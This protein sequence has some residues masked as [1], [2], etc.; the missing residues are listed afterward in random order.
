MGRQVG[1]RCAAVARR[2]HGWQSGAGARTTSR[3]GA[4]AI[5]AALA[6]A[7]F[8]AAGPVAHAE[9]KVRSPIV[10]YGELEIEHNGSL[11][12]DKSKSGKNNG[13]SYTN[14]IEYGLLPWWKVEFEGEWEAEPGENLRY[15]ATSFENVFQLTEQGKYWADFGFFAEYSHA[16]SRSDADSF[17]FGPIVQKELRDF[18]GTDTLHTVNLLVSKQVGHNRTDDTGFSYAWQSRYLLHPL[19]EPGIEFYG[20]IG[21]VEAPGKLADQSHRLGPMFAGE[22]SLAP[23]GA[24]KYELG[25]LFGLTRSTEDGAV[26]WRF[27]YEIP[28]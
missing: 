7:F 21:D 5:H 28:F 6:A 24:I 20:S 11:T 18:F 14:E 16:A 15:E 3:L 17:T 27:E 23:Y 4:T 10:E 22:V 26:R 2:Q 13:Q 25:Y 19:F 8:L 1:K 9:F 12:F